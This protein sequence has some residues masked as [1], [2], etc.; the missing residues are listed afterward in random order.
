MGNTY[1][2]IPSQQTMYLM[3]K[4]SLHKQITQI[5]TSISVDFDIDFNLLTK[6]LNVEFERN[7]ALRLRFFKEDKVVKQKFIDEYK[8]DSVPV[9]TFKT[10]E[11]QDAFFGKDAQKPVKFLKGECCRIIFFNAYNGQKGIYLNVCHLNLDAIGI[12]VFYVDLMRVY[13]ALAAGEEMPPALNKY[14]DYLIKELANLANEK[15]QQKA[16]KFYNEYFRRG[17]EPIYAGVHGPAFL[18]AERKKKKNPDL[19]VP[20]A[21]NPLHD[22]ADYITKKIPSEDAKKILEF[23][24]ANGTAPES[25]LLM[26]Y[27]TYASKINYRTPDVFMQLMCSKRITYKDM[28]TGGCMAQPLQVRTIIEE[29]K[30]FSQALDEFLSVRTQLYRHLSYPYIAARDLSRDIFGYGL[31]QG[32]ACMMFSWLP[33]PVDTFREMNL[34]FDYKF[35]NLGR[36]FTPLYAICHPDPE[37]LA[38]TC[39]YMYRTKLVSAEDIEALHTNAVKVILKGIENPDITVGELLD[40]VDR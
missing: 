31:I 7:D 12:L 21:Y 8:V 28:Q 29:N 2:L 38:L 33:I 27:R 18:E 23:C 15:K 6:A 26:G 3:V 37:D 24:K 5:P 30:T 13:K 39:N 32:P 11:E 4:Y 19:R 36:Y 14:E 10:K 40:M 35:Y 1:E 9:M 17:G 34:K 16:E 22:K 20:S 25:L